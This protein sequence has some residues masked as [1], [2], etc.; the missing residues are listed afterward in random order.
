MDQI[1]LLE[2]VKTLEQE[3]KNVKRSFGP[4]Y[5]GTHIPP[6]LNP[7][8]TCLIHIPPIC[9]F[10]TNLPQPKGSAMATMVKARRNAAYQWK[11]Y[12]EGI[13]GPDKNGPIK[14]SKIIEVKKFQLNIAK[15][16]LKKEQERNISSGKSII[17]IKRNEKAYSIIGSQSFIPEHGP[18]NSQQSL[19]KFL[20]SYDC[21][22]Q[23]GGSIEPIMVRNLSRLF[24]WSTLDSTWVGYYECYE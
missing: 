14:K 20:L 13:V 3:L 1:R 10:S 12:S 18:K 15:I 8:P 4:G 7:F 23:C 6:Y 5:D 2:D 17:T 24:S 22:G 21:G 19:H 11:I 9:P 16:N